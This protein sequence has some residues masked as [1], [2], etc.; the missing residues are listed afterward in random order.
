[1]LIPVIGLEIHAQLATAQKLFCA[2]SARFGADI[3]AQTCPLCLGKGGTPHLNEEAVAL[4]LR[5]ALALGCEVQLR[6]S[7]DRKHYTYPDLPKG[8]QITQF[9]SPIC[10]GGCVLVDGKAFPLTRIHIEEDAG[11][12]LRTNEGDMILDFNRCGVPLIE[13][14]T[15]PVFSSGKEAADFCRELRRILLFAGVCDGK[16]N[17]GSMRFDINLSLHEPGAPFGTRTE[18][19]N[20]NSFRFLEKAIEA[21]TARQTAILEA[22]RQVERQ[23][24]RYDEKTA[25]TVPM[26]DKEESGDYHY[27][28]DPDLPP[29]CLTEVQIAAARAALPR[30][31][32]VAFAPYF[33][34]KQQLDRILTSPARAELFD[35]CM[36][37]TAPADYPASKTLFAHVPEGA[38]ITPARFASLASL[39]G[40]GSIGQRD[41]LGMLATLCEGAD[42]D[43][44]QCAAQNGALLSAD[45][46][47][48][49]EPIRALL[50]AHADKVAAYKAGNPALIGF[51]M[52]Q[53][54]RTLNQNI[55]PVLLRKAIEDALNESRNEETTNE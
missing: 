43:P 42:F 46:R 26:R 5:A 45:T 40:E 37:A 20:L 3:N 23:T 9:F 32:S 35:A 22:G 47:C 11:K 34:S 36:K 38:S 1:M 44:M 41:A 50:C 21:E 18:I 12:I 7:F 54:K 51:F 19:K 10:T 24:L 28:P 16:M 39:L 17:E 6:S 13:I 30:D 31:Y 2:C 29:I 8:Y 33:L 27:I 55:A 53:I 49:D 15:E 14:V 25:R 48:L 4:A 52:G